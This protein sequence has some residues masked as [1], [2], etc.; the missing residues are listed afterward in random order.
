MAMHSLCAHYL[1]FTFC[2]RDILILLSSFI[3]FCQQCIHTSASRY[4]AGKEGDEG[5][6]Q[7]LHR[8]QHAQICVGEH[9]CVASRRAFVVSLLTSNLAGNAEET[10]R[11]LIEI[12]MNTED[13]RQN[14]M[15]E[16]FAMVDLIC[17]QSLLC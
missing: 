11:L 7:L 15:A 2:S 12:S 14:A 10:S 3:S 8:T 6:P 5:V 16:A 17:S 13:G 9:L 4:I 1:M